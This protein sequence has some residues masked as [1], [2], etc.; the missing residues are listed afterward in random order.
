MIRFIGAVWL[1]QD[2]DWAV[3][4]RRCTDHCAHGFAGPVPA[5]GRAPT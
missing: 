3:A 2:D 1:E 4:E 5:S